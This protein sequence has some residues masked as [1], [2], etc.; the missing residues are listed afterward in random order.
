MRPE[1]L[2]ATLQEKVVELEKY[3][4]RDLKQQQDM[5]KE[6][7]LAYAHDV[8][9]GLSHQIGYMTGAIEQTKEFIRLLDI[10]DE[11]YL[12]EKVEYDAYR[13]ELKK[14]LLSIVKRDRKSKKG[15]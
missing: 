2:K 11:Q 7:H 5:R 12:K 3:L 1:T 10:T 15:K 6:K 8:L 14:Q 4:K 13:E 9:E